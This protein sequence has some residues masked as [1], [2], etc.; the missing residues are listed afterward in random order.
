MWPKSEDLFQSLMHGSDENV[1]V[2]V[3]SE[4]TIFLVGLELNLHF[5][6]LPWKS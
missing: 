1:R 6:Q 3:T 5:K 4:S 2:N